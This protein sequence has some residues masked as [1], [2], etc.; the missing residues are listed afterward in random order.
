MNLTDI[1]GIGETY[2]KKLKR[3][4]VTS[5]HDLRKM[6][7]SQVAKTAG[8]GEKLLQQWQETARQ[9]N[10]LTDIKGI[11][12]TFEKKLK[13][14]GIH[15]VEDL[16]GADLAL[17]QKMG[18]TE[19]RFADWTQQARQM[20][21]PPQPVAK[22]A[23]VAED[24]GPGNAAITLQGETACVKIKEKV[25]E[26]VPVFRG[27]GMDHRATAESIAVHVDSDDTTRLWFDGAWHGNIPVTREGL[28]QR[29]KRK[30]IG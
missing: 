16:A 10:L 1:K 9:M 28:W 20:T 21:T 11:G 12:P 19:K 29:L 24:I 26:K 15:T 18:V 13:K 7:I 25:H 27:A 30:L 2:A 17:A 14:Q 22:K 3:A 4:G 8:L 23:V 6:N 5:I